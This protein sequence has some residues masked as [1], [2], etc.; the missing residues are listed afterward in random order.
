MSAEDDIEGRG[1]TETDIPSSG[2][3]AGPLRDGMLVVGCGASAG[4]LEAMT[5]LLRQL[6]ADLPA[7]FV[8][9]QHLSPEHESLLSSLLQQHTKMPVMDVRDGGRLEPGH[10]YVGPPGVMVDFEQRRLRLSEKGAS[11]PSHPID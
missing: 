8:L 3:A 10:V 5:Q 7:T 11:L 9:I 1:A 2:E 4:G 6:P